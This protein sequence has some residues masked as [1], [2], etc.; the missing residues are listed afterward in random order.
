MNLSDVPRGKGARTEKRNRIRVKVK[1]GGRTKPF[2]NHFLIRA[3]R[4]GSLLI[5]MRAGG[6]EQKTSYPIVV[7]FGPS[8]SQMLGH[9]SVVDKIE[10]K[11]L[12]R[13]DKLLNHEI[14]RIAKGYGK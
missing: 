4:G 12:E 9:K 13:V 1:R 7:R 5:A 6:K 10:S 8:I 14:D 3:K 11:A 2:N